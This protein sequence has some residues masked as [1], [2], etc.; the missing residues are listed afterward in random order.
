MIQLTDFTKPEILNIFC[1]AS[2]R[3]RGNLKDG[4]YGAVAVNGNDILMEDYRIASDTTNNNAEIKGIRLAVSIAALYKDQFPILN[5]FS[6]SQISILGIRDRYDT[7][8]CGQDGLLRGSLGEPIKSQEVFIEIRK[9][10]EE[11][12]LKINFWHQKGH[13]KNTFSNLENA[14]HVFMASNGIRRGIDINLIRFI[15]YYNN[16]VDHKSRSILYGTDI[17]RQKFIDPITFYYNGGI[18]YEQHK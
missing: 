12:N 1:D 15:S 2:I 11:N 7:W 4:C 13:V 9:I 18:T 6:D 5:I 17:Y 8:K 3:A 16:H 14:R 10:M